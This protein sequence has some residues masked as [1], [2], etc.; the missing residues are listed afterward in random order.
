MEATAAV[1]TST[2]TMSTAPAMPAAKG[3]CRGRR[4]KCH[5]QTGSSY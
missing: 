1:E 2:S 4:S 5:C 3:Q